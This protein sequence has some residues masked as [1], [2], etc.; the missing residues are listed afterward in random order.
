M[1]FIDRTLSSSGYRL[2]T[3]YRALDEAQRTYDPANPQYQRIKNLR[4]MPREYCDE[5]VEASIQQNESPAKT[6]VLQEL[7]ACRK[8]Q[9][10]AESRR[11]AEREAQLAEEE[12]ERRAEAEGTMSEC[13]CCY[14]DFPLNRMVHCRNEEVLHWFC[15]RCARQAA[16]TEI[17]N[18]KYELHC[19]STDT[20]TAGFSLEQR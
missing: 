19:M 4:R 17:G 7:Q 15:Y 20:C 16:E 10:N 1:A 12:N 5:H 8:I 11:L 3:A 2:F 6:E 18:S 14:G 9:K 13:A